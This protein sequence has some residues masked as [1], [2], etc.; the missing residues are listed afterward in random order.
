MQDRFKT[1]K[2]WQE[3]VFTN[4]RG[5]DIR[6]GF[7]CPPN[8]KA[9]ISI[10]PGLSECCEKYFEVIGYLT[11]NGYAVSVHDW[12]GQG[13]SSRHIKGEYFKRHITTFEDDVDDY[14]ELLKNYI[15]PLLS[16]QYASNIQTIILSHSMGGHLAFK[17]VLRKPDLAA[18]L[19]MCAPLMQVRALSYVPEKLAAKMVGY[20]SKFYSTA[21][22]P[23]GSDWSTREPYGKTIFTHDP[24]RDAIYDEW[25]E[26]N[27]KLKIGDPTIGWLNEAAQ[28]CYRLKKEDV[29]NI[30]IPVHAVLASRDLLVRNRR[31]RSILNK[32][33][34]ATHETMHGAYHEIMMEVDEIRDAFFNSFE[35]FAA[36]VLKTQ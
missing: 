20:I 22:V 7:V 17:S 13:L 2:G 30:K 16:K 31:T 35:A 15:H 29:S 5:A 3:A 12:M 28:S 18:G 19:F 34:S 24:Q 4:K 25:C 26:I 8:A 9:H 1:P 21:Y 33:P 32:I 10:S 6:Y 14:L 27:P 23:G 36:R 11:S